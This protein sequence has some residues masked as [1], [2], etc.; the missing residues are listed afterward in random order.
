MSNSAHYIPTLTEKL[1]LKFQANTSFEK[2]NFERNT[3]KIV[4]AETD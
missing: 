1:Q 4:C 3:F 2:C